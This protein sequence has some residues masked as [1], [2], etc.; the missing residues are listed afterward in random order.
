MNNFPFID[1]FILAMIAVFIINRLRNS[2]GKKTGNETDIAQK[3]SQKPSK[4]TESNPDKEIE[5]SKNQVKE[6]KNII[7]HKNSSINE[8]L[9]NIVKVDPSFTVENFIDGAKK[10]FEYI[11]VKYS[12]NDLKS[13]KSLLAPQILTNFTDQ[14]KLRQKQKQILGITILKIDDP[15]IID[16]SIVKNKQCFIKLEFK[17][18]QVQTTKDS[19]NKVIDGNDNLI[20]NISELWT[21]SKEIKNKNPNWILEK[22]E[23]NN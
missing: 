15:E 22:I 13:L 18:Q 23:E 11:L 17:S 6:A 2:L 16:V 7:L 8:K 9:N 20:L 10:A 12:E 1:I 14:I 3:F 5:K 21:F 19:N 4:F